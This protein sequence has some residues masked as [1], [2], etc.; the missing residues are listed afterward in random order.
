MKK[1]I[2]ILAILA[3]V[4][5]L[6]A[7]GQQPGGSKKKTVKQMEKFEVQKSDDDWRKEL[8]PVQ[9]NILR[10]KG[11]ERPFTG[12]YDE[13]FDEGTYYCAGCDAELFTSKTKYNS[14]CGWPAFYDKSKNENIIEKRD[15]SHGMIRTEVLCA[16]CGGHLGHV[17][18]DGPKPTGLRYCINS[19]ALRFEASAKK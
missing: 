12:E 11:T 9:F 13:L 3:F 5:C 1:L 6:T 8:T 18:T 7:C 17:F 15:L 14:G 10:Q 16:K 2:T 19:G 4:A